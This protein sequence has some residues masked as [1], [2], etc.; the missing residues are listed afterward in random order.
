MIRVLAVEDSPTQAAAL[1]ADLR[2]TGF[3][4]S[5][6]RNGP[7]ALELLAAQEFDV[8]LSDVVMPGMD[9][10]ELCRLVK[11]SPETQ[12]IPFVLLTSLRDPLD[13]V[14]GL[15]SGADNFLRKPYQREQLVSRLRT[16][17]GNRDLRRAGQLQDGMRLSFLDREFHITAERQQILD[18]LISTFEELVVASREIRA[19]EEDLAAAHVQLER[20]LHAVELER[21]RLRAVVDAV[22]VPLFVMAT[23]GA[24]THASEASARTFNTTTAQIRGRSLDDV[25]TFVDGAGTPIPSTKLPHHIALTE[26][27]ASSEG[28]AFDVFLTGPD[29]TGLPV[30]LQA[31]PVVDDAGV[32]AGCVGTAHVLG[33]LAQHDPVTGL[34][35]SAAFLDHAANLLAGPGGDS[36]LMLVELDRFDVTRAS[37]GNA[38]GDEVLMEASR[39]LRQFFERRTD[40]VPHSESLVGYLGGNR[41]GVVLAHLPDSFGILHMAES[42]RRRLAEAYVADGDLRLTASVGVAFHDGDH[43]GTQLFGAA[44]A[45]LHRARVCGGDRVELFGRTASKEAMDR[46]QLEIDLRKAVERNEVELHFQPEVEL[47][48]GRLVGFEALARWQHASRGAIDPQTFISLAEE[49]GTIIPLGR[50][51]LRLACARAQTWGERPGASDLTIAVNVSAVQLRPTF[52]AEVAMVLAET[53]LS[54]SRLML[55]MTETAAMNDPEA[56]LPILEELRDHGVRLALDDFGTG[57]SSLAY[58]TQMHFDQLKLDRGFVAGIHR[59]DADAIVPQSIIALGQSLGVPVLAEGIEHTC[60]AEV[61]R[62]LGCELGQGYLFSRPLD[63]EATEALLDRAGEVGYFI[64]GDQ[65]A[66]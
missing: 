48:T 2:S 45:A 41:F 35:N 39:R 8:V 43:R 3:T 34:P 64:Q 15:Q 53:G 52:A 13:V 59:G 61:L 37:F 32:L 33:A 16:A 60:Q 31:S 44:S 57:Y 22:P 21:S 17:V 58:L 28:T 51:L 36:A 62:Q 11:S 4:V 55:E 63:I 27:R 10:Y 25:V 38:V 23:G 24:V 65:G 42:A 14:S 30:V 20:E 9:G 26:G 47:A 18:L 56:T 46:L 49:S 7:E 6:A 29:G 66:P 5:L 19:R 50:H 54:P 40:V 1:S 12:T